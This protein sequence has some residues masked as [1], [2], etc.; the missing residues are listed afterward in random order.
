MSSQNPETGGISVRKRFIIFA[1]LL[2]IGAL[3]ILFRFASVMLGPAEPGIGT[4][5][6]MAYGRGPILDRN[7]RILAMETHLGNVTLWKPS[8]DK[9]VSTADLGKELSPILE[10]PATEIQALIDNSTSNFVYLKKSV[11][12][13]T[14]N[15]I[16]TAK[17]Q[18]RLMGVD[19]EPLINR[20][21]PEGRLASQIIG[22]TNIKVT[23]T[24]QF[25]EMIISSSRDGIAGIENAF[26]PVLSPVIDP[27]STGPGRYKNGSSVYLTLDINVQMILEEIAERIY[28][29]NRAEAVMFMAMDPRNGD[30]LGSVSVP[31][32]DPNNLNNP[33]EIALMDR[34]A[35]WSYEPGSVFK[36]F[37][38]SA[39]LDEG[40]IAANTLFN[41]TGVYE[42][43]TSSGVTERIRCLSAHGPVNARDI[44]IHSCN[45]GAA[46]ASDRM[47]ALMFNQVLRELGF[48]SR[49][50]AGNPGETMGV[51]RS[52]ERWQ[53]RS[54]PTIAM[55]Q[56]IAVSALQMI[57]AATAVANDGILV[58]PRIV[59]KI[60]SPD[61][62]T[63]EFISGTPR[64][65]LKPETARVMRDYMV[66]VTSNIGTGWRA[67]VDDISMAV[68]TGTAQM[69]DAKVSG[70]SDTDYIASCI[71]F[72]P[73]Q[74]PSLILYLA[75][76]KPGGEIY[77][78]RIA[79]PPIRE[80]AEELMNYLGIPRGRNPQVSHSG[81]IALP[82]ITFPEVN[83]LV[84]DFT[85]Y[86]KRQL[87]PL[88]LRDDLRLYIVGD[89][90][91][92]RQSPA[93]NTPVAADTIITL[94]LE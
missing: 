31:G 58:P 73:A 75:I 34:P 52:V 6:E 86:S 1:V 65:V 16:Q 26:N 78:G 7:G 77:G 59:S 87:L 44:I 32:Y 20:V 66:D 18:G 70:Y 25:E 35:I 57:Q 24:E 79:A 40:A 83:E 41:C 28:R 14:I 64:Q 22:F 74:S 56:E 69:Y 85:G 91:V 48:G 27:S 15:F 19:I 60:V 94:I 49:T 76:V 36:I 45:A 39:L 38:L 4:R 82:P 13:T 5:S 9:K 21:Y 33:S 68:K 63:E 80:A 37:S 51:F 67:N 29:E 92:V 8:M 84:P 55:G 10:M 2:G 62:K 88:L 81:V 11:D 43:V 93:P 17:T 61:G 12:E 23:N 46:Y 72:L 3:L 54:K 53:E 90:W 47:D 30:I 50:G 71:A 42:R 89:G